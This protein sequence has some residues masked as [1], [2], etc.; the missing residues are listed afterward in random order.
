MKTKSD[1]SDLCNG[2]DMS[3]FRNI[4]NS[5]RDSILKGSVHCVSKSSGEEKFLNRSD[6]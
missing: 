2:C 3:D 4:S 6:G 1:M 5:S